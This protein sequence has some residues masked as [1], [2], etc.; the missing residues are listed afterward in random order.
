MK[1]TTI[2]LLVVILSVLPLGI[3]LF[4]SPET[5]FSL[6]SSFGNFLTGAAVSLPVEGE[7]NGTG[8][9]FGN[10]A[11]RRIF[12]PLATCSNITENA[13]LTQDISS[14]ATCINVFADNLVL[15][16]RGF[17]ITYGYTSYSNKYGVNNDQGFNNF[18]AK[19]CNITQALAGNTGHHGIYM[20]GGT[21]ITLENNTI[22]TKGESS[23]A[24]SLLSVNL[25][26]I[27]NNNLTASGLAGDGVYADSSHYNNISHNIILYTANHG[28]SLS[29]STNNTISN[30]TIAN[31]PNY[32]VALT[33]S[34]NNTVQNNVI[35]NRTNG[36]DLRSGSQLNTVIENTI[37]NNTGD[38]VYID[39]FGSNRQ[40]KIV[41]NQIHNNSGG[42]IYLRNSVENNISSNTVT[43]NRYGIYLD[44]SSG[45]E[46]QQNNTVLNNTLQHNRDAGV[47][48][49][50][51]PGG[52]PDTYDR[53]NITHNIIINNSHG[54]LLQRAEDV[55][56]E[57]NNVSYSSISGISINE[58][59]RTIS[60]RNRV[61]N[62]TVSFRFGG[63]NHTSSNEDSIFNNTRGVVMLRTIDAV[64]TAFLKSYN[65]TFNNANFSNNTQ[66]N[67]DVEKD[68]GM[69]N[70]VTNTTINIST[71][72]VSSLAR[73]YIKY[74]ID[75]NVTNQSILPIQ[76]VTVKGL[77]VLGATDDIKETG[78]NGVTR[79]VLSESYIEENVQYIITGNHTITVSRPGYTK[80]ST[81]KDIRITNNT[82]LNLT[83]TEVECGKTIYE[84]ALVGANL[85]SEGICLTI[86]DDNVQIEGN[87]YT[88]TGTG[89]SPESAMYAI[90]RD[91]LTIT[92]VI[93]RNF[94]TGI[95]LAQ[96]RNSTITFST[97]MNNSYG[98][99]FNSSNNNTILDSLVQ[100]NT[101][102]DVLGRGTGRENNTLYNVTLGD[103]TIV[104]ISINGSTSIYR[105]WYLKVNVTINGSSTGIGNANVTGLFNNSGIMDYNT[106][107]SSSGMAVLRLKEIEVNESGT[108]SL[109]PHNITTSFSSDLGNPTNSTA[110]NISLY[111]NTQINLSLDMACTVPAGGLNISSTVTLC[112][113]T[114]NIVGHNP[115]SGTGGLIVGVDN[116]II[117]CYGT[118]IGNSETSSGGLTDGYGFYANGRRN[119]TIEGCTVS[120]F[121]RGLHF[122][123]VS[124]VTINNSA[125]NATYISGD[126]GVIRNLTTTDLTLTEG[127][128]IEVA[129]SLFKAG[130]T[131]L[132]IQNFDNVTL[133]N[134]TFYRL[135]G[136]AA[137][138]YY[139]NNVTL[140][141]NT[142]EDIDSYYI[143]ALETYNL[144][145][146]TTVAGI[147]Q[148]NSWDELCDNTS[149]SM[150]DADGDGWYDSGTHYP[151]NESFSNKLYHWNT[152]TLVDYGPKVISCSVETVD[153]STSSSS[154]SSTTSGSSAAAA[155]S[156]SATSAEAAAPSVSSVSASGSEAVNYA[157]KF[158]K[159]AVA[160]VVETDENARISLT[161]ENTGTKPIVV[162][163]A[164]HDDPPAP[165]L[166]VSRAVQPPEGS[167]L[168]L[169]KDAPD[170]TLIKAQLENI[171]PV[172]IKAGEKKEVTVDVKLPELSL[173]RK[174]N[175]A[176]QTGGETVV[177]NEVAIKK[178]SIIGSAIDVL[179]E[180]NELD[181]YLVLVNNG[182]RK[183]R[184]PAEEDGAGSPAGAVV[185]SPSD[186]E[187]DEYTL[188]VT[189][190]KQ[191][192]LEDDRDAPSRFF[193]GEWWWERARARDSRFV[194]LY[195]PYKV[196]KEDGFI[197]AQK[198]QYDPEIFHGPHTVRT[199]LLKEGQIVVENEF[200]VNLE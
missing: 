127:G 192:E 23:D 126:G 13:E 200:E 152:N 48:V 31:S 101:K 63:S 180:E 118:R 105:G 145:L 172:E 2:V 124:N 92:N 73:F 98:V 64:G 8:D 147:A 171:D 70:S 176:I 129:R 109:T 148:G 5:S 59:R 45:G 143:Y 76:N 4:M 103:A 114:Y 41:F 115:W 191:E 108:F 49:D 27:V 121:Y 137:R 78:S 182:R 164:L 110:L 131:G 136:T 140:F 91:G 190:N 99:M 153:L 128:N 90:G 9:L 159:T 32:G 51:R 68:S 113:G 125:I 106:L 154:S 35:W 183:E 86:G 67:I 96:T 174:L 150:T 24:I 40:N 81:S 37:Y 155:A 160:N 188:E 158:L 52:N 22:W 185:G 116:I 95:H 29:S 88:F 111:N 135:T 60:T 130:S 21:S 146:N 196:K 28:V 6:G 107:T 11:E 80:N 198:L 77:D 178:E 19:N 89:V 197:F 36:V 84:D 112:P 193:L 149:L 169:G 144:T 138:I 173:P 47:Y 100:N 142:F 156:E 74:P 177:E 56:I 33:G 134:N 186:D 122:S 133:H 53:E 18:T 17:S 57:G 119:V 157:K 189:I 175:V 79:L 20:A 39:F 1:N 161:L 165:F 132:D 71:I 55:T 58:S 141:H 163:P 170:Y 42:G 65:N 93:I 30:N 10:I 50:G 72:R 66:W 83:I 62:N 195:G 151:F 181:M 75:I 61:F 102:S 16:C 87:N 43:T 25:S 34:L 97:I 54:I 26:R 117:T 104:N 12:A 187:F 139:S 194:D 184:Q 46:D 168:R 166:V 85:S 94:T 7:E 179:S 15:D 38:G 69:N 199:K 82:L 167:G 120:G 3:F 44:G 162:N 123:A 14:N